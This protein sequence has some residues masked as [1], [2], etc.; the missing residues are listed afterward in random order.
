[1][2]WLGL[3]GLAAVFYFLPK[4][5]ER[6]WDSHYLALFFYWL[7]ILLASWGGIPNNAPVPAW[8]PSLSTVATVLTLLPLLTV[9]IIVRQA[10]GWNS[11]EKKAVTD[12][13]IQFIRFGVIAFL[14]SGLMRILDSLASVSQVTNLTW[15][16]VATQHLQCYGFFSMVMFGALYQ[17]VPRIMGTPFPS[18]RLIRAHL[19]LAALGVLFIVVPLALGGIWEGFR[20]QR[21]EIAFVDIFKSTLH[22]LRVSTL[23]DLLIAGG[24]VAFLVNLCWLVN[25]FYRIRAEAAYAALT[26]DLFKPEGAKL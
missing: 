1:V 7:F 2:V 12:A 8:M 5:T 21:P 13:S 20:L 3:V 23:G 25:E 6:E 9:G 17:I 10:V 15:F 11:P 22:F 19:W 4:L 14:C 18:T 24:H 26:A 16:T